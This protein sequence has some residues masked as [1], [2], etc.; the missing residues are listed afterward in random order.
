MSTAAK[1]V[2]ADELLSM[3]DDGSRYEL[4][5]GE[6]RKMSPPGFQH[7]VVVQDLAWR[8]S[9]YVTRNE[10]GLI[11]AAETGFLIA[12]NPDTVRAPDIGFVTNAQLER[13]GLPESY[14]PEAPALVVEVVSP[15]DTAEEVD[16][17]I[18]CWLGAGTRTAW[19]VYPRGRTLTAYRSLQDICVLCEQDQLSGEDQIPGFSCPVAELFGRI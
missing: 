15:D 2:T 3:P 19:V 18:R 17:K 14:F 4:L 12:R 16:A 10:L 9:E 11:T 6:L 1:F 5:A 8:L 13:C 7:G